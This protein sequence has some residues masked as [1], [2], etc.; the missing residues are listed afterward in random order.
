MNK[1]KRQF[2]AGS[3]LCALIVLGALSSA[4]LQTPARAESAGILDPA[5]FTTTDGRQIYER[6]CQGCHMADGKGAVGAGRYPP[7]AKDLALSS[8]QYMALT[9]LAGRRNMPAFGVRHAIAF[10]GPPASL[11]DAQ[12]AAVINYVRTHFDNHY[13]DSITAAEVAALDQTLH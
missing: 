2:A 7:L 5:P 13:K 9:I 3:I 12:I 8:R 1:Q 4:L 10:E 11:N 6:I